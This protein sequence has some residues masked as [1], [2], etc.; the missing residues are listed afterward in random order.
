MKNKEKENNDFCLTNPD[1]RMQNV[2]ESKN[3]FTN[4]SKNFV[5]ENNVTGVK[6]QEYIQE[7]FVKPKPKSVN[8]GSNTN[9][10]SVSGFFA[11]TTVAVASTVVIAVAVVVASIANLQLFA[12]TSDSLTFY[13]QYY[14]NEDCSYTARL[15]NSNEYEEE[16]SITEPFIQ[17]YGLMPNSAYTLEVVDTKT[18]EVVFTQEYNTAPEDSYGVSFEAWIEDNTLT[19]TIFQE[20]I[21][22][23][24]G[25]QSY[26]ISVYDAKGENIFEKTVN[27]LDKEYTVQL[28][29]NN[30]T[31]ITQTDQNTAGAAET[32][33]D[34]DPTTGD[35]NGETINI[36]AD[37]DVITEEKSEIYYIGVVYQKDQQ[38]IG[39]IQC[40]SKG[41]W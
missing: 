36:T 19:I 14:L 12:T 6:E 38:T 9:L 2:V 8:R 24:E 31:P 11:T 15:F 20:D 22:N 27:E 39:C 35:D 41:G 37:D 17:F 18:E 25:I 21:L 32:G 16:I 10:T 30:L 29:N 5:Q 28:S 13:V 23:V 7:Q 1:G 4:D 26:T 34:E 40:A 33:G 3:D